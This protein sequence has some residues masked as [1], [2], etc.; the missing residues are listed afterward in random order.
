M[1]AWA[2]GG[3]PTEWGGVSRPV[4]RNP[5][6]INVFVRVP[7]REESGSQPGGS[8]TG[9]TEKLFM[10]QMFMC[11]FRP[12]NPQ[13]F[14]QKYTRGKNIT[15]INFCFRNEFPEKSHFSYKN[16]FC[17]ELI[18]RKLHRLWFGELQTK[19]C[20]G[21]IFLE[22]LIS[23]AWNNVFGVNFAIISGWSALP[24]KWEAYCRTN[25]RRTAVQMGGILLGFPS[26][27]LR[28]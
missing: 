13:H 6:N 5:T 17:R 26:S 14:P 12:L 8:V 24:Y 19:N 25:G 18:S 15:Y 20:L 7:G 4:A 1:I 10:C 9:G 16:I 28:I 22:N 11:L 3:L 2:G 27:R 23:V 21:N